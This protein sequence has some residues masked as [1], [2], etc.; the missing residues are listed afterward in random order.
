[1]ALAKGIAATYRFSST[2]L[3]QWHSFDEQMS[4]ILKRIGAL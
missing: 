2:L 4:A 1:V 3:S